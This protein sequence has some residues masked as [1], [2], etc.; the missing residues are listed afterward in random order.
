M[1]IS[2]PPRVFFEAFVVVVTS[3][4]VGFSDNGAA[5]P[6]TIVS[7][8]DRVGHYSRRLY[9]ARM[10]PRFSLGQFQ[11]IVEDIE[12]YDEPQNEFNYE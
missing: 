8:G 7:Y 3:E 4:L 12:T 2:P 11:T 5:A 6:A 10:P 9:F 1:I